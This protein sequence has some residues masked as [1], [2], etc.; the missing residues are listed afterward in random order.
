MKRGEKS[1]RNRVR[2]REMTLAPMAFLMNDVL[3]ADAAEIDF[4]GIAPRQ[5]IELFN[6]RISA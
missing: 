2:K 3:S 6:C 1:M 5:A 4:Q